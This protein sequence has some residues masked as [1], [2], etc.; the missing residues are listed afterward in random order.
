MSIGSQPRTAA[1]V[2]DALAGTK[3]LLLTATPFQNSLMELYGLT[4]VIDPNFFGSE[5]H[6]VAPMAMVR[7]RK[8]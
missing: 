7:I 1:Y 6:F 5:K 8:N 2:R 3:K 4:T